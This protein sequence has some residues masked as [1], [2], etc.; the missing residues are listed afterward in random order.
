MKSENPRLGSIFIP[1]LQDLEVKNRVSNSMFISPVEEV[2]ALLKKL[3]KIKSSG[4]NTI[5]TYLLNEYAAA[6]A[7]PLK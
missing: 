6:F 1:S 3:D 5:P 7:L 2:I 4:P